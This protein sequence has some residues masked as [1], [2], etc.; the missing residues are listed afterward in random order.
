MPALTTL[1]Q[2][3]LTDNEA[4][5]YLAGLELGATS[6]QEIA[7]KAGVKRTTVY[8]VI[9]ALK[10]KGLFSESQK[11]A[12]MIFIAESPENLVRLS[13]QRYYDLKKLLPELES[14]YNASEAKPKVRF[15]EGREG[16]LTVYENILKDKPKEVLVFGA[17]DFWCAQIDE[18]YEQDWIERR[19]KQG[20]FLRWLDFKTSLTEKMR[21]ADKENLRAIR[22]LPQK[23]SYTPSM[24]I[25]SNKAVIISGKQKKFTAVVIED[26]ETSQMF[27]QLF[28]MFW[29]GAATAS[30]CWLTAV[31]TA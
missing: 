26:K 11:G 29:Q 16:Y 9:Q 28:E 3:G 30:W 24:F 27:K 14:I 25:Y 23:F 15:Y 13:E 1:K 20:I 31:K 18:K 17:Y 2:F 6:I 7:K 21:L 8:A 22:F 10:Q 12:K 19:V 4:K 5:V